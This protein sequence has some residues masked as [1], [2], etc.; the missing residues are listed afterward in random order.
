[1]SPANG[2]SHTTSAANL[3]DLSRPT[4]R[5]RPTTNTCAPKETRIARSITSSKKCAA[6]KSLDDEAIVT[7]NEVDSGENPTNTEEKLEGWEDSPLKRRIDVI[8]N[9][10]DRMVADGEQLSKMVREVFSMEYR[11]LV[12][13]ELQTLAYE[14]E[15]EFYGRQFLENYQRVAQKHLEEQGVWACVE[16][17][18]LISLDLETHAP[19]DGKEA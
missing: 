2:S 14:C 15:D 4:R 19:C 17:E 7:S 1:M 5:R 13:R 12:K 10:V 11:E 6:K 18:Q 3:M 9:M 16:C 8:Y